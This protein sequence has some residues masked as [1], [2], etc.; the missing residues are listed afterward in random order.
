MEIW[1]SGCAILCEMDRD[2][3]YW[4]ELLGMGKR[5]WGVATDDC[6]GVAETCKGYVMVNAEN[7]VKSIL[8]ALEDGAFYSSCGPEIFDFYVEDGKAIVECSPAAKV[9]FH[10][11]MHPTRIV[12]ADNGEMTRAEFDLNGGWP[13]NYSYIRAT[14]IDKDGKFAWTNPIFLD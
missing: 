1:N 14:V 9:R 5:I 11:D 8:K 13:G 6:H 7:D 4:D 2:A 10:S 3:S 12:F